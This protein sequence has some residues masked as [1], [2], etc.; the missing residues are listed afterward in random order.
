MQDHI[1]EMPAVAT[2]WY[3]VKDGDVARQ[4]ILMMKAKYQN[5]ATLKANDDE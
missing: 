1:I 3:K 2:A 4:D 5:H